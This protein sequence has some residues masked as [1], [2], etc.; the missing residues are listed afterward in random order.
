VA[1]LGEGRGMYRV[2]VGKPKV[3]R[4]LG[5]PRHRLEDNIKMDL[6]EIEID[7][8]NWIWLA[9]DRLKW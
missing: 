5:R 2:L 7:R 6:W 1:S 4:P 3:K 9:Q 8:A